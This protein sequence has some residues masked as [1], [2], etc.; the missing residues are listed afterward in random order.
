MG[1]APCPQ[2]RSMAFDR[3]YVDMF[4]FPEVVSDLIT[5]FE[6]GEW[7][8]NVNLDSLS[9]QAPPEE[10][11][12]DRREN[13]VVWRM[14]RTDLK[15]RCVVL[16]FQF[17]AE[18]QWG[19]ALNIAAKASLLYLDEA[20][21]DED[22][23]PPLPLVVP[24]VLYNGGTRWTAKTNVRDLIAHAPYMRSFALSFSHKVIEERFS[25]LLDGPVN[26]VAGLMFRAQQC[27]SIEELLTTIEAAE[28]RILAKPELELATVAWLKAV[29]LAARAP[30]VDFSSV[31]KL[32]QLKDVMKGNVLPQIKASAAQ[33]FDRG[34]QSS[35]AEAVRRV[36][37]QL[38]RDCYGAKVQAELSSLI[39]SV[40]SVDTL[41]QVARWV[42]KSTRVEELMERVRKLWVPTL[43]R[44]TFPGTGVQ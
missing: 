32:G 40:S 28:Q 26:N 29:V 33:G 35:R 31:T 39:G 14:R 3:E 13:A 42:R 37:G 19:M 22:E 7:V 36:V 20:A 18:A 6:D 43:D 9:Q 10:F 34:V 12:W 2:Q 25:A 17:E 23:S 30:E 15:E 1:P 44:D 41:L 38:A 16:M 5:M 21:N 27:R 24:Y 8:Q 4:S 11:P